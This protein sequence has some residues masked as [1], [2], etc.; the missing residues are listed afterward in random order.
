MAPLVLAKAADLARRSDGDVVVLHVVQTEDLAAM[1]TLQAQA[2]Q[3][4][5]DIRYRL[6]AKP[7]AIAETIVTTAQDCDVAE[8]VMGKRGHRPLSE[9]W[10][11]SVSQMVLETSPIPV[12]VLEEDSV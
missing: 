12:L 3:F 1:T 4:L 8:I 6:V 11:G 5:A 10:L 9:V 7:G 2:Q